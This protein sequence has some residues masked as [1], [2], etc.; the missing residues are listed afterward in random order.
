MWLCVISDKIDLMK[1]RLPPDV[2][3][4][5]EQPTDIE[6]VRKVNQVAFGRDGEAQVVD[7]L[8]VNC[9]DILSLVAKLGEQVLGHILFSMVTIVQDDGR[10]ITGM[11]LGPLA[12]LPAH[13]GQG[14][15][16]ALCQ[17]GLERVAQRGYPFVIVLGHPGYYPRFGFTKASEFGIT[18]TF[19]GVP[20]DAFMICVFDAGAL[21]GVR[22]VAHYRSE[23]DEIS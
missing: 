15:G 2:T 6:G 16:S 10:K 12:V 19:A 13:Q 4:L 5:L 21:Q 20:D 18:S 17:E 22:G 3:I 7:R 23:F 11:G 8:R 14:I 9:P 1:R